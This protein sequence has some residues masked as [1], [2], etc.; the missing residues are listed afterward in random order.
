MT[1][2]LAEKQRFHRPESECGAALG[3]HETDALND[4]VVHLP[5]VRAVA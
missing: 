2:Y 5:I 3:P 4:K 1:D